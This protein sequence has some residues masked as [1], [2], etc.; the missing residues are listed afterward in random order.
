M[1]DWEDVERIALALPEVEERPAYGKRAWRVG[2]R[3]F[4]WERPLR[5]GELE[6]LG[7]RAPQGPILGAW[8]ED[9]FVKG[10]MLESEPGVYFTTTHFDTV[11]AVLVRLERISVPALEQLAADA[12]LNRAPPRLAEAYLKQRGG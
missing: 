2:G 7:R 9:L 3:L 4:V 6:E 12:W 5:K 10:A 8:V 1:A 11:P